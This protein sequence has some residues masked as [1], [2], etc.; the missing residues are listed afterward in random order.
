MQ[1]H[2]RL[3]H[4]IICRGC[5]KSFI[6]DISVNSVIDIGVSVGHISANCG[7][8]RSRMQLHLAYNHLFQQHLDSVYYGSSSGKIYPI[9]LDLQVTGPIDTMQQLVSMPPVLVGNSMVHSKQRNFV[10]YKAPSQIKHECYLCGIEA[11]SKGHLN[12]HLSKHTEKWPTCPLCD[13]VVQIESHDDMK[14]HLSSAHLVKK[15]GFWIFQSRNAFN[16]HFGMH[17]DET[18]SACKLCSMQFSSRTVLQTHRQVH[19]IVLADPAGRKM[20]VLNPSLIVPEWL[21]NEGQEQESLEVGCE[22]KPKDN[23]D[24]LETIQF[25]V[26]KVCEIV[27]ESQ[28][29]PVTSTVGDPDFSFKEVNYFE[30][31]NILGEPQAM[32]LDHNRLTGHSPNSVTL[33]AQVRVEVTD[34]LDDQHGDD[35]PGYIAD[36]DDH[37][38]YIGQ[39]ISSQANPQQIRIGP[40]VRKITDYNG[41]DDL[42]VI[43][44]VEKYV[45]I[46]DFLSSMILSLLL[47]IYAQ[48]S[49][50]GALPNA[51]VTASRTK[52]YKCDRCS[53]MYFTVGAL[54]NHQ[55]T[56]HTADAGGIC[57]KDAHGVNGSLSC[58]QCSSI[59]YNLALYQQHLDA[60]LTS[61]KLF[62]GCGTCSHMF[63]TN[64]EQSIGVCP[65]NILHYQPKDI[66]LYE[67]NLEAIKISVMSPSECTHRSFLAPTDTVITCKE[68]FCTM[69]ISSYSACEAYKNGGKLLELAMTLDPSTDFPFTEVYGN[70][71]MQSTSIPENPNRM[72]Q[73]IACTSQ[74][75]HYQTSHLPVRMNLVRGEINSLDPTASCYIAS[76]TTVLTSTLQQNHS[77]V[78][79][80]QRN[81]TSTLSRITP[82][83]KVPDGSLSLLQKTNGTGVKRSASVICGDV[84]T[85]SDEDQ[86]GPSCAKRQIKES[87]IQKTS[88]T[89]TFAHNREF[90]TKSKNGPYGKCRVCSV[91]MDSQQIL[92][93]HELHTNGKKWFCLD[94]ANAQMHEVDAVKHYYATHVKTAEQKAIKGGQSF[95]PLYYNLRCPYPAC[96]K[97][98]VSISALKIHFIQFHQDENKHLSKCCGARFCTISAR[99]KHDNLHNYFESV[100][101]VEGSCCPLCGTLNLWSLQAS[102][103]GYN[104]NHVAI[105]GLRRYH[106]CRDCFV[107]FKSDIDCARMK[108][109]FEA[110]HCD[111]V[112][113]GRAMQCKLCTEIYTISEME[114]HIIDKHLVSF[115]IHLLFYNL[116]LR[117]YH[118]LLIIAVGG[119][120]VAKYLDSLNNIG[121]IPLEECFDNLEDTATSPI[122]KT[123]APSVSLLES[124]DFDLEMGARAQNRKK[125]GSYHH[126]VMLVASLLNVRDMI[127][128]AALV[129]K[130][131]GVVFIVVYCFVLVVLAMPFAYMELAIG[132]YTSLPPA[133]LFAR[134]SPGFAVCQEPEQFCPTGEA[135]V[136]GRC[137]DVAN[138]GFSSLSLSGPYWFLP[139]FGC[140]LVLWSAG[141]IACQ[142]IKFFGK[143]TNTLAIGDGTL[144]TIGTI[145]SFN[146]NIV[147]DILLL[148]LIA[149]S[150]RVFSVITMSSLVSYSN[151]VSFFIEQTNN[152]TRNGELTKIAIITM[153]KIFSSDVFSLLLTLQKAH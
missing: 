13:Q 22:Y 5:G 107:C 39:Q 120:T 20:R 69:T 2:L 139:L 92:A 76:P 19:A 1:E 151:V 68:C 72:G 64:I 15:D 123:P 23:R 89:R 147:R 46:P 21:E 146:N 50:L 34:N 51:I 111:M 62:Y 25:L 54:R 93:L 116:L 134:I 104:M 96:R 86:P 117:K 90:C 29:Y 16:L 103:S 26:T 138:R 17:I 106:M 118:L 126:L 84:I 102:G 60:H 38:E 8:C 153:N 40:I 115:I 3:Y 88:V 149:F 148:T 10:I 122:A 18:G 75:S 136:A 43:A 85:L 128:F 99:D 82:S 74:M 67:N 59:S 33:K 45:I 87:S 124:I 98:I 109:H 132:Q 41:D 119:S 57:D 7:V 83:L 114:N 127:L 70:P 73:S 77:L 121:D 35:Q 142:G 42:Q 44:E 61:H 55:A 131:G 30:D 37:I 36:D 56:A 66:R 152:S 65:A 80:M 32:R 58:A 144:I 48:F 94:C 12:R 78:S 101:G 71:D 112:L 4:T 133:T 145:S 150:L 28:P 141:I 95:R 27:E 140:V 135:S 143:A 6:N 81:F 105:H 110:V 113:G 31:V 129:M 125:K 9:H 49:P 130:N 79:S 97:P 63:K 14:K 91:N 137:V 24:I 53:E 11:V 47:R 100:N 52:K 108:K